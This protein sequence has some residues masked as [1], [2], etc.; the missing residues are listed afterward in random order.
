[1]TGFATLTL[2]VAL[3]YTVA[4]V[5]I[6]I[7]ISVLTAFIMLLG[8][9][10]ERAD[11]LR[12][13]VGFSIGIG[14]ALVLYYGSYIVDAVTVGGT[15]FDSGAAYDPPATFF[16]FRNQLRDTVRILQNGY[17]IYVGLSLLG[18]WTLG[19]TDASQFHRRMLWGGFVTYL[20]MLVMKDPAV[21]PRIFLHAKED[22]FYAPFACLLA[23]LP[24]A[25]LWMRRSAGKLMVV[26][27]FIALFGLAV[28]DQVINTDTL[29]PQPIVFS[30]HGLHREDGRVV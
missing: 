17:P 12:I 9:K 25:R 30:Q 11:C 29:S 20:A 22:L 4:F 15:V 7:Y 6:S 16:V 18:L 10:D 13:V 14:G 19:R 23:A 27:I 2:V 28:H 26:L 5:Q 24:L 1:V 3:C 21:L 8:T